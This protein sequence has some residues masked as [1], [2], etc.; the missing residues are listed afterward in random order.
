VSNH[1][2]VRD[3][4]TALLGGIVLLVAGSALLYDAYEG[5]GRQRPFIAKFLPG[6]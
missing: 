1:P 5:R 4:S 6:A 3:R 2:L